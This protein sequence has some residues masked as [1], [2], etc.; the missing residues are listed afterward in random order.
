MWDFYDAIHFLIRHPMFDGMFWEAL[1]IDVVKVDPRT[2][3]INDDSSKNTKTEV[4][5]EAGGHIPELDSP[6]SGRH[7][8]YHDYTLDCGGDTFEEAIIKLADLV[9]KNYGWNDRTPHDEDALLVIRG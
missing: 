2:N 5:L 7:A 4:W 1:D 6:R 8:F 3:S 9:L